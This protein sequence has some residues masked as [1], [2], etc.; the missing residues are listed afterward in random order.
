MIRSIHLAILLTLATGVLAAEPSSGSAAPDAVNRPM[1]ARLSTTLTRYAREVLG[2]EPLSVQGLSAGT[3][4]L[5]DA[6]TLNPEA[7]E[8]WRLLL[9]AAILTERYDLVERALQA[10]VKTSPRDTSARLKRLWLAIDKAPTLEAKSELIGR[11]L[12]D[13]HRAAIGPEVA[14]RLAMRLALL[15]RRAGNLDQFNTLL[16]RALVWD[17]ANLEAIS[18]KAGT[19]QH[20]EQEDPAA[21]TTTLLG[22]YRAN[23]TDSAMAA[24]LGLYLLEYG[25]YRSAARMLLLARN[26]EKAAGRD[27]GSDLDADLVMAW[28]GASEIEKAAMLLDERQMLLN[29]IFQRITAGQP[30]DRTSAIEVAQLTAPAPPKLAALRAMMAA[31]TDDP[32]VLSDAIGE[33]IRSFDHLDQLRETDQ[34]PL[35]ARAA[36]LK[37][38][39][40][41]LLALDAAPGSIEDTAYR[42]AAIHPLDESDQMVFD[43][44]TS[45]D[46]NLED[47]LSRLRELGEDSNL[48]R[49]KLAQLLESQGNQRGAAGELLALWR[50]SPSSLMGILAAHK[51]GQLIGVDELP[52]EE[53]AVSMSQIINTLPNV[54][55]RF[56]DEPSLATSIRATPR[57]R[58]VPV[59][60]PVM[61]DFQIVNHTAEPLTIGPRGPIR[62]LLLIQPA[63]NVP[64]RDVQPGAP[65]L[66]DI[67]RGLQIP[68]HDQLDLSMDLRST[69]VGT[70]LDSLPLHGAVIDV[71]VVLNVRVATARTS[72]APSSIP[73]PL[74]GEY[75]TG[76][77]RVDGQRVSDAW[78]DATLKR[79]RESSRSR[80]AVDMAL[81]AHVVSRQDALE[82][83][84]HI[85][86]QQA[87]EIAATLCEVWPRLGPLSQAWLVSVLPR[88]D[89]LVSLWSLV[90]SSTEPLVNR[91]ALM[92]VVGEFNDPARALGDPAVASG[93]RSS[94]RLVRVLAEWIEATL[95]LQAEQ[96]FGT[97][98]DAIGEP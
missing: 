30:D 69:W 90:E 68:P 35:P 86:A 42:I 34:V 11:Y 50:R 3:S 74:G 32:M 83:G 15:Y 89:R 27:A 57:S 6:T 9:D 31:D 18:V 67:G 97:D 53:T 22:L 79:F 61:I 12:N 45:P 92:R 58:V 25:A 51:L 20:L 16:D 48:A 72:M 66:I 65:V 88:V 29:Q 4:F 78:I 40:W 84:S 95:Q 96:K 54:F 47:R 5:I 98:I 39:L 87:N 43:V 85:T 62:D 17:P 76:E 94:E 14:S 7:E 10:I 82:G 24:E 26:I 21:W 41:L 93:L 56:P 8:S 77:I 73:G 36:N 55:D 59:F 23:P 49:L 60:D 38:L 70:V 63:V 37:R 64:Y 80:D 28:W 1:R 19:R 2:T 75:A 13:E 33:A 52:M 81:L 46:M 91:I 71:E 44:L